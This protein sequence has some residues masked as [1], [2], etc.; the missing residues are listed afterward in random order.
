MC[1][2]VI[3][4]AVYIDKRQISNENFA[5]AFVFA[6]CEWTL[7][8]TNYNDE[9]ANSYHKCGQFLSHFL[10]LLSALPKLS[11]PWISFLMSDFSRFNDFMSHILQKWTLCSDVVVVTSREPPVNMVPNPFLNTGQNHNLFTFIWWGHE[12]LA[13]AVQVIILFHNSQQVIIIVIIINF[14]FKL[15]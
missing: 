13:G 12:E 2:K 4:I 9:H 5:F 10:F 1:S 6:R 3:K 15:L 8:F 11:F 7:W 14:V